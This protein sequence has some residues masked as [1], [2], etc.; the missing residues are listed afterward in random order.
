MKRF[1]IYSLKG[2]IKGYRKGIVPT[3][4]LEKLYKFKAQDSPEASIST[5][6]DEGPYKE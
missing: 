4:K 6:T 1:H 2:K 5:S 3:K